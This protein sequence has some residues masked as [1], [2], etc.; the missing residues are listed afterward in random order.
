[1]NV[2]LTEL[3]NLPGVIVEDW[4][5]TETQLILCVEMDADYATCPSCG[6]VSKHLHANTSYGV[7]TPVPNRDDYDIFISYSRRDKEF[8]SQLC[9]A[10]TQANQ[11]IWVD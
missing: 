11:N 3:L 4:Q 6:Q 7:R 8:V 5:Q 10:L 9:E 1:M 2:L